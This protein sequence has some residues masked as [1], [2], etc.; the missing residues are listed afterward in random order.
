MLLDLS[1]AQ[2]EIFKRELYYP[3]TS[4]NNNSS[5]IVFKKDVTYETINDSVND[6]VRASS[7]M[8][9]QICTDETGTPKMYVSEF[10]EAKYP[11]VELK[12]KDE[13]RK[14]IDEKL[15]ECVFGYDIPLFK[16]Y[17]IYMTEEKTWAFYSNIHHLLTD[18]V[19]T[20]K[21]DDMVVYAIEKRL[22]EDYEE[23]ED[24]DY[25]EWLENESKYLNS[26][27][28]VRDTEYWQEMIDDYD[29]QELRVENETDDIIGERFDTYASS[30]I[31]ESVKRFCIKHEISLPCFF[32]ALYGLLKAKYTASKS[33]SL[34][35]TLHNRRAKE[36]NA[37]G[38]FV[39]TLPLI[40]KIDDNMTVS[41]FMGYVKTSEM[42]FLKHHRY[43][44]GLLQQN[45]SIKEG[46][47]DFGVTYQNFSA[48]NLSEKG[49]IG[50]WRGNGHHDAL[51]VSISDR[52]NNA[53]FHFEYDF[54]R[55]KY[56]AEYVKR[57]HESL[58][59][60]IEQIVEE[61]ERKLCEIEFV[62]ESDKNL[63]L[64]SFNATE[65]E[66]PRDK[67]VVEL[68]EEQVKKTPD[69]TALVFEDKKL[70]YAEL[71]ARAN[72]LAHKLRELGVK[73]DD[74]VAIIADRSI[75][76]IAGIYG[77]I[78]AGGAY[79][80][81]D[82]TLPEDRINYMISDSK[83]KVIL[84]HTEEKINISC[85]IP[86][87]ELS[88]EK[89]WNGLTENPERVN[90]PE[91]LVYCIY[92]SGT[93]GLPKGVMIQNRSL[94]NY[95]KTV[96][97][98]FYIHDGIIP[99]ITNYAFDLTVTAIIGGLLLGRALVIFASE[100]KLAKY[101]SKNDVAVLKMTPS[102]LNIL[103]DE[104]ESLG[105]CHIHA[106]MI[107]GEALTRPLM[108]RIFSV[109]GEDTEIINEYGPTETT[110]ASSYAKVKKDDAITIGKPFYNT[111][112]YIMNGM[113]FCGIGVPG[114]L[115]IAGDGLARGYLNRPELTAEKFVKNPFGEGRMYRT[116]D[117]AR[118]LPDGNIEYLGRIDEQVKIRGF[119][120]E[121]GEIESKIREIE[122]IKDCAVIAKADASG[123]KAIYA[124][125][126]S[127]NEVSVSEIRDRLSESL[128]EYMVPAFMMQIEE[129]PVTRNGKL[130]KRALPEIETKNTREY[131]APRN[132]AEEAV[133]LA[134]SEVLGIEIVGITDNFFE[135]GGDS[136]KA[137]RIISKLRSLGY[138]TNVKNIMSGK[139][140][141][142]IAL[143]MK[144]SE[145][146]IVYDQGE[147]TGRV[148]AT[149]IIRDFINKDYRIPG[150]Y[151]QSAIF[152][153]TGTDNNVLKRAIESIV[154]HH[155]ILRAVLRDNELVI[156]PIA[157]SRMFDFYE[158]DY[159]NEADKHKAVEEK[160]TEIQGSIDLVNGPLVKI[161]VFELG[162]TKQ[163]MFC[164]H[165]LA[166]DGVSWRILSEDL[167]EAIKQLKSGN[168]V[169]LPEKTASFI[170]WSRKLSEYGNRLS[171]DV[172][173]YWKNAEEDIAD[174]HIKGNHSGCVAGTA[175]VCF[176]KKITEI[177]STK[178]SN[179]NGAKIDEVLLAGLANA[180]GEITGQEKV[181][182]KLEGHGR[183]D[184]HQPIAIDRTV[185][186]FT[187]I[188]AISL[189]CY[190]EI[191]QA[192]IN[193]KDVVRSVPEMGMGYGYVEHT[194]EPDICFNYLGD[195]GTIADDEYSCG[196]M[197]AKENADER[198]TID[199][200]IRNGKLSFD[201]VSHT[202]DYGTEFIDN[203]ADK[204]VRII[205]EMADY[206][207]RNV[208][209]EKTVSD[210]SEKNLNST[211]IEFLNLI[212]S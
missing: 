98:N 64:N 74:F 50:D 9:T 99:L 100:Y 164:I 97:D 72:S 209:E 116:G 25:T 184:I 155:D 39:T 23:A 169:R 11:L 44:Y 139:N 66:Y 131:V 70:T 132:E 125:Y 162:D 152:N 147:V 133:C 178:S 153:V 29:G 1:L 175:R 13:Y 148:E 212:F 126:T 96:G 20:Y 174:G 146:M 115:C 187:N 183:E 171:K 177:L 114:E 193:A 51:F 33:T 4:V 124:Y 130:D 36:K 136:I 189:N 69:N 188:Y 32:Y 150:Y 160:C 138:I 191:D 26:K 19:G 12:N 208:S 17:I 90:K 71:N 34:A 145:N 140:A 15:N 201:I 118:W 65:T 77:I 142:K 159:S 207:D 149:P 120:I 117:L 94:M 30:E 7:A 176:D 54:A 86:V 81:I 57:L 107:G 91:N 83:A 84:K 47:L 56:P 167:E 173:R 60:M 87:I 59:K 181:S 105:D 129:I 197:V 106:L 18:A 31:T 154:K 172:I 168:D 58:I 93:T 95:V 206:C 156:L 127:D 198:I 135:I 49:Y 79:V 16:L 73:P 190:E 185:G 108:T 141:E 21:F 82:P 61:S 75:E 166:V 40:M 8:R 22:G 195:F 76:M 78:K 180:V 38:M 55:K 111:Q 165:H 200:M 122:N 43:T 48:S 134:F 46:L 67:T 2:K 179:V 42:K 24:Y 27:S 202:T 92:T 211:D 6:A 28:Y 89:N 161:A 104:I 14:W 170:E 144:N 52:L 210:L 204:F 35:L 192:I 121:L 68:F 101:A 63:I 128:P 37:I 62:T 158:F 102:H 203:L 163:M 137:I 196:A 103:M 113:N 41:E 88:D 182:V 53:A 194:D 109:I 186:W 110:V 123:D 112:I 10:R 3:E 5:D 205:E 45:C 157:E 119:R 199:G 143:S 80:P 85:D 151:N